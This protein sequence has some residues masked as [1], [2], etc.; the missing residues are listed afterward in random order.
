MVERGE[1]LGFTLKASYAF[2]I[3]SEPFG[4][5]LDRDFT[6]EVRVGRTVD[7][8]HAA[9]TNRGSD[10]VRAESHAWL[11]V[12][13]GSALIQFRTTVTASACPLA[14]VLI[15]NRR[16]SALGAYGG[17]CPLGLWVPKSAE[18]NT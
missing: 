2:R 5:Y 6:P 4:Q 7:L 3:L 16:P 17:A 11:Q 10:F 15:R 18:N 13:F 9:S 14:D 8:A 12:H 1:G